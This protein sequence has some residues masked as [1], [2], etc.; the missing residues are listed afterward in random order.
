MLQCSQ[1]NNTPL[2][3]QDGFHDFVNRC[4]GAEFEDSMLAQQGKMSLR[5]L[6]KVKNSAGNQFATKPASELAMDA[7]WEVSRLV[8]K[9][10]SHLIHV[11]AAIHD[12]TA[13]LGPKHNSKH[14]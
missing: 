1:L 13:S 8:G 11:I 9:C 2:L 14:G 12:P 7:P 6:H 5:D 3:L 4:E 10:T